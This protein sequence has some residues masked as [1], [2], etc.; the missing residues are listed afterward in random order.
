M[1]S[2]SKAEG[3]KAL[4]KSF[5]IRATPSR[6]AKGLLAIPHKFESLFP[7]DKRKIRVAFDDEE[8]I[9]GL[10]FHPYDASVKE[11]RIFGLGRWFSSRG[12]REGD[13]ISISV[14]DLGAPI[15]RISLD[16]YMRER[17]EQKARRSLHNTSSDLE[18]QRQLDRLAKLTR[19]RPRE[20]AQ[21]ELLRIARS[22]DRRP[23]PETAVGAVARRTSTPPGIRVLLRELY[24]GK[25]QLCSFTFQRRDGEPYFEVHHLDPHLGHHPTNLL[26]LCPNCHAQF[27]HADVADHKWVGN[28]L[29]EVTISGKR[30]RVRQALA[31][32]PVRRASLAL[33]LALLV[34]QSRRGRARNRH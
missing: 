25:C 2:D 33:L 16:R 24:N 28:W 29:V 30:F 5:T 18:A 13:L 31:H 22:A 20:A 23:R 10:T 15:Y 4:Q 17:E 27:E 3:R 32:D 7:P 21:D 11:S 14:E 34:S 26:V 9:R 6:L 8:R 19:R 12:V 1:S